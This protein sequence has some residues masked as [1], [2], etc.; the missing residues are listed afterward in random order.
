MI[1]F[2]SRKAAWELYK[3]GWVKTVRPHKKREGV[4]KCI[5]FLWRKK[6][7]GLCRIRLYRELPTDPDKLMR[8]LDAHAVYAGFRNGKEWLDE[9]KRLNHGKIPEKLYM[10]EV[11]LEEILKVEPL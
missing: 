6:I 1:I 8:I 4:H 3:Y 10:Y 9:I 2:K 11:F 7:I 5:L